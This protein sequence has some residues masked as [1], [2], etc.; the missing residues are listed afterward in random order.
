M[1]IED[2]EMVPSFMDGKP[3]SVELMNLLRRRVAIPKR[4]W[5]KLIIFLNFYEIVSSRKVGTCFENR[6]V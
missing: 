6:S 5:T 4:L 3:V 2:T 1:I